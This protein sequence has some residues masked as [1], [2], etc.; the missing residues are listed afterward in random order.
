MTRLRRF[1]IGFDMKSR[2]STLFLFPLVLVAFPLLAAFSPLLEGGALSNIGRAL[3]EPRFISSFSFGLSQAGA[4][5]L[6]ALALG[7][8]GAYLMALKR[9][10]GKRFLGALSS[11]PFC[12][13]PLIVALAFVLYY[14]RNGWLNTVLMQVFHL[15]TPP[16]TFLYSFSGIVLTHGFYNFPLVS[17]MVGEDRKS[18]V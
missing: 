8:P 14:G 1:T 2:G 13:P 17:R 4:S 3:A 15:E 12:V 7:F 6:L 18:V 16:I 11:V 5:T 9:F 10:P